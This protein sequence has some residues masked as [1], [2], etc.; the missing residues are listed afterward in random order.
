VIFFTD[1]AFPSGDAQ[2]RDT[3]EYLHDVL[4]SLQKRALIEAKGRTKKDQAAITNV[5]V[6]ANKQD[7][8]TALPPATIKGK[9]EKEIDIVRKTRARGLLD[10]GITVG[11]DGD[12][13]EEKEGLGRGENFSFRELEDDTGVRLEVVGGSARG[14]EGAGVRRWEEW[15]GGCL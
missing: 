14:D 13:V 5:L 4:L 11:A 7:L 9:L 2:I 8:F 1:S 15:I 10:S 6:A 12:E 3:A